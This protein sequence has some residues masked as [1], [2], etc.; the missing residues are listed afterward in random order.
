MHASHMKTFDQELDRGCTQYW[1]TRKFRDP[2]VF[3]R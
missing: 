2:V 3:W 1:S